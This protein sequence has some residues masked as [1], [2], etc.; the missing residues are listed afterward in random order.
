MAGRMLRAPT[1][2]QPGVVA[3]AS[4]C[5]RPEAPNKGQIHGRE[6]LRGLGT[7]ELYGAGG[8][9]VRAPLCR[10]GLLPR[11]GGAARGSQR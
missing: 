8:A 2:G 7:L 5:Q 11:L 1:R 6:R 9:V 4:R 3:A 10:A